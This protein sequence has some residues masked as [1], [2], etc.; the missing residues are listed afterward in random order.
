MTGGLQTEHIPFEA[1]MKQSP[2]EFYDGPASF[3]YAQAWS[4]IHFFYQYQGGKYR[5]LI[6]AYY[7]ALV[8][9]KEIDE[10]FDAA[11]GKYDMNELQKEW[12]SHVDTLKTTKK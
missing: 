12:R 1:L 5:P 2:G 10:A 6:D 4:M 9:G 3:K 7:K 8:A 11:F